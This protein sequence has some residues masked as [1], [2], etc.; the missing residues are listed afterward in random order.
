MNQDKGINSLHFD[1]SFKRYRWVLGILFIFISVLKDTVEC[2]ECK[3]MGLSGGGQ[4]SLYTS[5]NQT[6]GGAD[7]CF[8]PHRIRFEPHK[9]G[10]LKL[11]KYMETFEKYICQLD[12]G[13][14]CTTQNNI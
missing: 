4:G 13:R 12:S 11:K 14:K 9:Y 5:V 6:A 8:A 2:W 3:G 10:A 7:A 1:F